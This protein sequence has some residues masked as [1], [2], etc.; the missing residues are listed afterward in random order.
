V[1]NRNNGDLIFH[2]STTDYPGSVTWYRPRQGV[3]GQAVEPEGEFTRNLG[4]QDYIINWEPEDEDTVIGARCA[5]VDGGDGTLGFELWEAR[6][7]GTMQLREVVYPLEVGDKDQARI[8]P[9]VEGQLALILRKYAGTTMLGTPIYND[10]YAFR[11]EDGS[12]LLIDGEEPP[13]SFDAGDWDYVNYSIYNHC[14][15]T[16]YLHVYALSN[17]LDDDDENDISYSGVYAGSLTAGQST[18]ELLYDTRSDRGSAFAPPFASDRQFELL[19]PY[20]GTSFIEISPYTYLIHPDGSYE[21][22]RYCP[23][24][25]KTGYQREYNL[26]KCSMYWRN[27]EYIPGFVKGTISDDGEWLSPQG[28]G[29]WGLGYWVEI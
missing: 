11:D 10:N 28:N 13:S 9:V 3:I 20:D 5:P 1:L 14:Q 22:T 18:F 4:F 21:V 26:D 23:A 16:A 7:D 24:L 17:H 2:K 29:V 19:L 25:N 15:E 12:W 8:L 6:R 27:G